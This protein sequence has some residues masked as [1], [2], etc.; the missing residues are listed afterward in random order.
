[1]NAQAAL[2]LLRRDGTLDSAQLSRHTLNAAD[3]NGDLPRA[4]HELA[5]RSATQNAEPRLLLPSA[6]IPPLP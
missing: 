5:K 3:I 1:M 4:V 2:E 6:S